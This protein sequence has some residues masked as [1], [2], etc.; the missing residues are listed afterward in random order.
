[1]CRKKFIIAAGLNMGL[2]SGVVFNCI[3]MLYPLKVNLNNWCY[4]LDVVFVC[5]TDCGFREVSRKRIYYKSYI[6]YMASKLLNFYVS[7]TSS[8]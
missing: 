4:Q 7:L 6:L 3:L 1:M 8:G 2:I 5:L